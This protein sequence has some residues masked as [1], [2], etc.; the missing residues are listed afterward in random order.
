MTC[1][2]PVNS[3]VWLCLMDHKNDLDYG[4]LCLV[5]WAIN[6]TEMLK[7]HRSSTAVM[8]GAGVGQERLYCGLSEYP[9]CRVSAL[10][11]GIL[12]MKVKNATFDLSHVFFLIGWVFFKCSPRALMPTCRVQDSFSSS[13]PFVFGFFLFI[14]D[15]HVFYLSKPP[16]QLWKVLLEF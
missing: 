1:L 6:A 11:P 7:N 16:K 5:L 4:C 9:Q 15:L 3:S 2:S 10:V 13:N 8:W 12:G 14:T